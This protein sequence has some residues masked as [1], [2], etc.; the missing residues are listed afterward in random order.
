MRVS[1]L[2]RVGVD[3]GR[4]HGSR[5]SVATATRAS[6]VTA[7]LAI[8]VILLLFAL[9]AF[10]SR[11][12]LQEL[13]YVFT[14]LA[15]A[16]LWNLLAGCTGLISVG[17]QAFVGIGAYAL[18][19]CTLMAGLEPVLSIVLAGIVAGV[20]AVPAA[21][22]VFRLRGAYFAIGTWVVAEVC[23]LVLAQF[24]Q[25]GGGTGTSLPP[26]TVDSIVGLDFVRQLFQVRGPAARDILA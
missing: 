25:L 19:A 2:N 12:L 18:F 26:N 10:A 17:Q 23:R 9:P 7:R 11:A 1:K 22:I 16:Q 8:P 15:L 3:E 20:V 6:T 13:F 5:F 4:L 24:K 14:M 21:L